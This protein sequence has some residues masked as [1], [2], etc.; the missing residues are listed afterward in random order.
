METSI[1]LKKQLT[2]PELL[3]LQKSDPEKF[4]EYI[5]SGSTT[6]H[7]GAGEDT[8]LVVDKML[9]DLGYVDWEA[10][11]ANDFTIQLDLD[12][13]EEQAIGVVDKWCPLLRRRTVLG[14][15]WA[16][17]VSKGGKNT[18]V[19]FSLPD[20]MPLFERI[21]WQALM[22]SDPM[23]EALN[24]IGINN[25]VKNQAVLFMPKDRSSLE[26]HDVPVATYDRRIKEVSD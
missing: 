15:K 12:M 22:G 6:E 4:N 17:Y 9:E 14:L 10:V 21:A 20:A 13:N 3:A 5:K 26:F 23:R 25:G 11:P 8:L 24:L 16:H 1:D 18:H 2:L 19:I 7:L